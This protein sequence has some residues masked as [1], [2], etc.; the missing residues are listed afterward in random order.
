MNGHTLLTSRLPLQH[1]CYNFVHKQV[2]CA[3]TFRLPASSSPLLAVF[4]A[5][6]EFAA[7]SCSEDDCEACDTEQARDQYGCDSVNDLQGFQ[8]FGHDGD[9]TIPMVVKI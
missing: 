4:L 6:I 3:A 8:C 2:Q 9:T 1:E 7:S 5:R